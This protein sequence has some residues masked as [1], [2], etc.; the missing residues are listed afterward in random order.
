MRPR[1]LQGGTQSAQVPRGGHAVLP[2]LPVPILPWPGQLT[3]GQSPPS[4]PSFRAEP[5]PRYSE[6]ASLPPLIPSTHTQDT[7][8]T[9]WDGRGAARASS[10]D[11][12][13]RSP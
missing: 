11:S 7:H 9:S 4:A 1:G 13:N 10:S 8:Q 2:I 12:N 3:L 5:C 6:A